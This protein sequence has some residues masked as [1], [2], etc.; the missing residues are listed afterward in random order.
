MSISIMDRSAKT[1]LAIEHG[2]SVHWTGV[3]V[4]RL[5]LLVP[6]LTAVQ[7]LLFGNMIASQQAGTFP[8]IP[9]AGFRIRIEEIVIILAATLRL[10][11]VVLRGLAR[12]ASPPH[13][14]SRPTVSVVSVLFCWMLV[15]IAQAGLRGF[16]ANNPDNLMETRLL[17]IPILYFV[18]T[19]SWIRR[20]RLTALA[21]DLYRF[22]IP[23]AF[24]LILSSFLPIKDLMNGFM[25][26]I[27]LVYGGLA[28][29]QESI[30]EFFLCLV[31]ARTL[32]FSK[33]RQADLVLILFVVVGLSFRISK[34]AWA[35]LLAVF[36]FMLLLVAGLRGT[37]QF[38]RLRSLAQ[39]RWWRIVLTGV[40]LLILLVI[41]VGLAMPD[42]LARFTAAATARITRPDIGG[43]VSGGRLEL[44]RAGWDK[45]TQAPL[46]GSGTGMWYEVW[47][48]G[49]FM[50]NAPDH[51]SIL[52]FLTRGGLFTFLPIMILTL[53]Y[54]RKGYYVCRRVEKPNLRFFV[55]AC[56]IYSLVIFFY[57]L[58]GVPQ[59]LFEPQVFFWLSVAVVLNAVRHP[60]N[61][62]PPTHSPRVRS[63]LVGG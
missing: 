31:L 26:Q 17:L 46:L 38:H 45:F 19:M 8:I 10:T 3:W 34:P 15:G 20:A 1:N 18:L 25:N 39:R 22:L 23:L 6:V 14:P 48:Q 59:T 36:V 40:S 51:F 9:L 5:I 43:D 53:W 32:L 41:V 50:Y 60:E 44:I 42:A 37:I 29:T 2:I 24:I 62:P 58:F 7:S 28:N 57:S 35:N 30:I 21:R 11:G 47:Y 13:K 54:I 55:V 52:W 4:T 27:G 63:E 12:P 56:Y 16:R 61:N 33:S 49:I